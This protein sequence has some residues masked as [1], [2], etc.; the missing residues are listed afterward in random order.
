MSHSEGVAPRADIALPKSSTTI[1]LT[2]LV[3]INLFNYIDRQVLS[4]VEALGVGVGRRRLNAR[5]FAEVRRATGED[6]K[7]E[8]GDDRRMRA[9]R[10]ASG[11]SRAVAGVSL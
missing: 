11:G 7:G 1:A 5:R 8:D 2:L 10:C 4:A 6:E 3:L 9:A